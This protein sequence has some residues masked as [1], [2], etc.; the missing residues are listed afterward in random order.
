M[1][2]KYLLVLIIG[3]PF[4]NLIAQNAYI[5]IDSDLSGASVKLNGVVMGVTPFE[6][7]VQ[8]GKYAI[9][10]IKPI[11]DCL[12]YGYDF[13]MT[14]K[15]GDI[16][17][18]NFS[19][20]R[21]YTEPYKKQK[22]IKSKQLVQLHAKNNIV[23]SQITDNRDNRS[24]SIVKIGSQWW[25]AE[26]AAFTP[27]EGRWYS[28]LLFTDDVEKGLFLYYDAKTAT[29]VCPNGWHLPTKAEVEIFINFLGGYYVGESKAA[30]ISEWI[31]Y[32]DRCSDGTNESGFNALPIG[33]LNE[34]GEID[35]L[36]RMV[37]FW[38]SEKTSN[39][40][41][42]WGLIIQLTGYGSNE[43][44]IADVSDYYSHFNPVRCIKD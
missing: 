35:N 13:S 9:S 18:L 31:D 42:T 36:G 21:R 14:L 16:E 30:S 25:F 4:I 41:N 2:K 6:K 10:I 8:A 28:K 34:V 44:V 12:E 11:N 39:G 22:R 29:K 19:L 32:G 43:N 5:R 33:Q 38:G 40:Y 17:K 23:F 20:P 37:F 1:K 7:M 15:N 27:A 3:F 24:Y 26:N